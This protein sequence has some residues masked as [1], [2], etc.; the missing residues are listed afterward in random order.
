MAQFHITNLGLGVKVKC[1][2]HGLMLHQASYACNLFNEFHMVNSTPAHVPIH[3]N[4]RLQHNTSIEP[5]NITL[6]WQMLGKLNLHELGLDMKAA[7]IIMCDNYNIIK[8]FKNP[9]SQY[10]KALQ[11]KLA[12]YMRKNRR[13]NS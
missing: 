13:K 11:N 1:T 2:T 6:Y 7:T 12:F 9:I 4:T 8:F 3:E 5:L 10:N